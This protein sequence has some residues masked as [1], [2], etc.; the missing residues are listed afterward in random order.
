MYIW[1]ITG[2]AP[3]S[4]QEIPTIST[5][6][7]FSTIQ[8]PSAS[9]IFRRRPFRV[10]SGHF[11]PDGEMSSGNYDVWRANLG[12]QKDSGKSLGAN[13]PTPVTLLPCFC[14]RLIPHPPEAA[15]AG[16]IWSFRQ[17]A[18]CPGAT[19]MSGGAMWS[20]SIYFPSFVFAPAG[21]RLVPSAAAISLRRPLPAAS[22][23]CV[24]RQHVSNT[25]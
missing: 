18:T 13:R 23:P 14:F 9:T 10:A 25:G 3:I 15:V 19:M 22:G 2:D 4:C 16:G 7:P 11:L 21:C 20:D 6:L 12:T 8:L 5:N 1:K 17:M 24:W